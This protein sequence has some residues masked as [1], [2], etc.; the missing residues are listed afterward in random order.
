MSSVDPW[1]HCAQ[2]CY[3]RNQHRR[4]L[5]DL[6]RL[7]AE[8]EPTPAVYACLDASSLLAKKQPPGGKVRHGACMLCGV[9]MLCQV[10]AQILEMAKG[11]S[12]GGLLILMWRC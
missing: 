1:L 6:Y 3:Q 5:E 10:P 12:C 4:K 7:S 9:E 11:G 2:V 8:Y